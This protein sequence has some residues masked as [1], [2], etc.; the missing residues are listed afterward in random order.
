LQSK[1]LTS[2]LLTWYPRP[3]PSAHKNRSVEPTSVDHLNGRTNFRGR[4]T[5]YKIRFSFKS[6]HRRF[7]DMI[8]KALPER[9]QALCVEPTFVALLDHLIAEPTSTA[10]KRC[11]KCELQ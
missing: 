11:E 1:V 3:C 7:V 6:S 2:I 8:S 4:K 10:E 5:V 9:P